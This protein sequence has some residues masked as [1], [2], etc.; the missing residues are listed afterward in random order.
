MFRPQPPR[1]LGGSV[2]RLGLSPARRA[3]P[4][5]RA[6]RRTAQIA[7]VAAVAPVAAQTAHVDYAAKVALACPVTVAQT[8]GDLISAPEA[9][10]DAAAEALLRR[11]LVEACH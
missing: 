11:P 7:L 10:A 8:A 3:Q 1:C 5:N 4:A 2:R 6:R 9:A